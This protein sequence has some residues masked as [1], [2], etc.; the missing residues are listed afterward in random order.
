VNLYFSESYGPDEHV[1][2]RVFNVKMQGNPIFTNLDVFAEA[3]AN[4]ALEKGADVTVSNGKLSIEFDNVV[5]E[6]KVQAIEILPGTS[7]P[8][9]TMSFKYPDGTPVVG[10]LNYAVTSSLLS[11]QGSQALTNGTAQSAL[12]A[13]P[14]S[15]GISAQFT[16]N[17][18]LTDS[19]GHVLWQMS[20]GMNPA[21]VNLA[22]VQ[23]S[24]LSVTVQKL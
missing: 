23:N 9:L 20:V 19:A 1:G 12:F 11:F 2:A 14:S 22:A 3:G 6:A 21:S 4:A 7:G 17:L 5:D 24:A 13:N 15:L 10:T 8:L 16:V 18:S